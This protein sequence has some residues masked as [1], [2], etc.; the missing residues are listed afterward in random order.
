[1]QLQPSRP[2]PALGR[3]LPLI[4]DQP[5]SHVIASRHRVLRNTYAL[6]A[7]TLLFSGAT[8]AASVAF[9]LPAPGLLLTLLAYF[10][11][12]Y[13]VHR[14]Q[15]SIAALP[16]IFAL[17]GFMGYTLGPLLSHTLALPSG[18]SIIAL[19]M[20]STGV[21]F[22]GMSA[23][24]L[25]SRRDFSF[26]GGMLFAGVLVT[27]VLAVAGAL[28]PLPGLAVA[29]ALL[30]ALLSC[31]LILHDTSR[32]VNG[33]ET[34]YVLAAVGLYVSL[35]NLFTSMLSLFGLGAADD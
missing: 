6:L 2:A 14:W 26:L 3:P 32:I 31:G 19:S 20:A 25:V 12:M 9:A 29:V 15:N 17:T 16:A 35:F 21:A 1:M 34:N 8:A 23:W 30:L 28:M 10:G 27:L 22:L 24:A 13:A 18:G 4:I 33:G 7:L 11:L 5:S